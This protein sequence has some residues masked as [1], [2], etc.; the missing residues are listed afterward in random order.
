[1][2][3]GKMLHWLTKNLRT[4]V[5]AFALALAVW[6][7][8]VTAA[9][10][11]ETR[12]LPNSVPIEFISQDPGLIIKGQVPRQVQITL[13]APRSVWDKLTTEKDAIHALVDLSG[14]EA[15]T[16]RLDVQVQINARP[17]R[18]I[19][20]SPEKLDL[21]LEKLVTRS[22]PLELTLT[23]EPAIGYQA[24]DPILNPAEV[25]I[26]GAQSLMNQVAHLS[27]SL[28]LSDSRQDIQTTLPIKA[29]DDKGNLVTGLTMHPDN[30]QVSLPISQQGGYRDL[31]VKV[32]TIGRPANGYR[33]TNIAPIPPVVTVF[34]S[35]LELISALPGYVETTPLDLNGA[36]ADIEIRLNLNLPAGVA[37]VG[38]PN[39]LVQVGILAIQS[40]L[41]LT[42]RPV[43]INNLSATLQANVSPDKVDVILSG[44]LP[45]LDTL[46]P[47]D[48]HVV[49]DVKGLGVGTHH[50][51]PTIQMVIEGVTVVSI[52][53]G[54]V[55]VI[56]SYK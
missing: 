37:L 18:L 2:S 28:D 24:G 56:I 3:E 17:V 25:I 9:D 14:L 48:V 7:S 19:S 33:L 31:A 41:K 8:A 39:V 49:I 26:S 50:L 10:P 42:N 16:H 13:R 35:N 38:E 12:L 22:L 6:I 51:T 34:S 54:T 32:V 44:P 55:E 5:L 36:S 29:L 4:V 43:E 40:S 21:T 53:P 46:A 15:G 52:L 30:V 1:M 11:D 47:S 23:G 27:L 20:F 45:V